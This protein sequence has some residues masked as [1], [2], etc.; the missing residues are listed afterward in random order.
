MTYF[1]D[2]T[3]GANYVYN[4]TD[5]REFGWFASMQDS[6]V[7]DVRMEGIRCVNVDCDLEEV[8]DIP[9]SEETELWSLS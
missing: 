3:S 8:P 4:D 5:T 9:I 2:K 1:D 6:G 7:Q